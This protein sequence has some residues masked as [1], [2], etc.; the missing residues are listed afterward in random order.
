[1]LRKYIFHILIFVSVNSFA[2]NFPKSND[3]EAHKRFI[4]V[5]TVSIGLE[6]F[7]YKNKVI[8]N[9]KITYENLSPKVDSFFIH[10]VNFTLK[11]VLLNGEKVNYKYLPKG[12]MWIYPSLKSPKRNV[13]EIEY[14]ATPSK[15][16]FFVGWD[17]KTGIRKK[18][19]WTQ[20]QGIDN[21]YW[22]PSYDLQDEKAIY[23]ITV[24]FPEEYNLLASGEL[25]SKGS[26]GLNTIWHYRT[27]HPMSSYLVMLAGGE[28]EM[29]RISKLEASSTPLRNQEL[30][31]E[32][33]L[34]GAEVK[35]NS[36]RPKEIDFQYW[37][38]S[39]GEDKVEPTYRYTEEIMAY[40]ENEIGVKYPWD[41]YAQIPVSDFKHG[42]MENTEA[43]IFS[44]TY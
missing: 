6:I 17:D 22:F 24:S 10:A 29:A 23:D 33:L 28:Y 42:A 34:S 36:Q 41:K 2:Q 38:Y 4:D 32:R 20:G 25:L 26:D 27:K 37:Y 35:A 30:K 14:S 11:S 12:G 21:R 5:D 31:A 15:G 7:P 16:L 43:T 39:G 44:D 9:A 8:G 1:M 18:Q 40:F 3:F 19:I 13:L